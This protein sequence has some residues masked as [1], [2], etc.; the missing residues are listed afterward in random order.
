MINIAKILL[1][2]TSEQAESIEGSLAITD[3]QVIEEFV[4][5]QDNTFLVSFPRTGSHWL[6]MLM[7]K[8]FRRPS[9]IRVFYYSN[10]TS[11]LTLH[12]HDIDLDIERSNV[13]YLYRDPIDTVFSQLSYY[14]EPTDDQSRIIH[15]SDLYGRHLDKWLYRERFTKSKTVVTYH[16][17]KHN[18]A[19]E[20]TKI[21]DHFG[22]SLDKDRLSS[23]ANRIT[24]TEVK[25]KTLHDKQV[26][27]ITSTY[28]TNR[29]D[30]KNNYGSLV[31][32]CVL[33]KRDYLTKYFP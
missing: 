15:W 29:Q 22:A 19:G 21:T 24:K 27:Q 23:I 8:Y 9:L 28:E 2:L 16:G 31:W 11:Y 3:K 25:R 13:I 17:L 5:N 7:E 20:F 1:S 18:M 12:T 4:N 33:Q 10:V 30:F 32:D 14:S 6:R 26:V